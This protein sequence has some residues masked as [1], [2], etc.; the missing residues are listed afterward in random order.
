MPSSVTE[1]EEWADALD[2]IPRSGNRVGTGALVLLCNADEAEIHKT[3]PLTACRRAYR[4]RLIETEGVVGTTE[5]H[6]GSSLSIEAIEP[7]MNLTT[8]QAFVKL[9]KDW[10]LPDG[11]PFADGLSVYR[12]ARELALGFYYLWDPAAP[13]EWLARRKKWCSA[14]RYLLGSNQR[15][16]DSELQITNAVAAGLY[17]EKM[18]VYQAWKEIQDT[19]EPKTIPVWIDD[20][21]LKAAVQ[22]SKG[23]PGII[24]TEHSAFAKELSRIS[25]LPYF[26]KKGVDATGRPIES[27]RADEVVIASIASNGEGRNLQAWNR[28]LITSLPA[29]GAAMEQL[30]GRTHREGQ[31]A[32]EVTVEYFVTCREHAAALTQAQADAL[33]IEHSTGQAQKVLYADVITHRTIRLR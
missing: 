21:A 4:R 27:A 33:Y 14:C 30:L 17:P 32:D 23:G 20:S 3:D 8:D 6:T 16:L 7:E 18:A 1:L 28:N 15:N 5:V 29:N 25:G 26:G 9:R 31:E 11:H 19:F 24:W 12:H 22:W 13:K 2:E 10:E